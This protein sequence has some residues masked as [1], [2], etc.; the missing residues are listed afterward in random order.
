MK[1][2]FFLKIWHNYFFQ[3]G[4]AF[5]SALFLIMVAIVLF[6]DIDLDNTMLIYNIF[7][8]LTLVG[9][10]YSY[11]LTKKH[12]RSK[13]EVGIT[14][15]QIYRNYF[16]NIMI[17]LIVALFLVAYYMFV[18]KKV[19]K[20]TLTILQLFDFKKMLFL[21]LV[22]LLVSFIGFVFGII[23]I[24]RKVFYLLFTVIVMGLIIVVIYFSIAYF[25]NL[26]L[27]AAVLIM[28]MINYLLII[29]YRIKEK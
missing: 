6:E 12:L 26:I 13:L 25:I 7:G 8:T 11:N 5:V 28:G 29:N 15:K 20:N 18:Y 21:P 1:K 24:K 3:L 23:Q 22:F 17:T 27:L 14:R 4:L 19:I 16:V 10:I 9:F 2:E